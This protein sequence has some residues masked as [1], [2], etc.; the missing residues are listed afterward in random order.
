MNATTYPLFD[1]FVSSVYIALMIFWIILVFHIIGD[2]FRSHDL[3]G[4][5]KAAWVL[6]I[7]VFPLVG[8]LVYLI[9][10]GSKMHERDLQAMQLRQKAFEDYIRSIAHSRVD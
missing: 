10:R 5:A 1:V 9:A 3:V 2:I 6:F 8:C 4:G 7:F